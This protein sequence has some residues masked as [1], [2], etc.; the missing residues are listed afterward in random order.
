MEILFWRGCV[1]GLSPPLRPSLPFSAL[2]RHS[3]NRRG[4]ERA[5]EVAPY[6]GFVNRRSGVQSSQPAPAF[7]PANKGL[8]K[9]RLRSRCQFRV[10]R[11]CEPIRGKSTAYQSFQSAPSNTDATPRFAVCSGSWC[12]GMTR[13]QKITLGEMRSSG[14]R[15]LL[16]YCSAL[17]C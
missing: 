3:T 6:V 14:V 5:G 7:K 4:T 2:S 11:C 16:I 10:A 17:S 13:E 1:P 8:F 12:S 9:F 15:G